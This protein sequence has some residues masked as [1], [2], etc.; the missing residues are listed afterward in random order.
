MGDA[1]HQIILISSQTVLKAAFSAQNLFY[2]V[3]DGLL[4][5]LEMS[6]LGCKSG[7]YYAGAFAFADDIILLLSLEILSINA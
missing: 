5:R 6:Q 3:I 1:I 7:L 4:N 2:L